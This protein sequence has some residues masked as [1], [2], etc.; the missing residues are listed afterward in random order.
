MVE[1]LLRLLK[2]CSPSRWEGVRGWAHLP[3]KVY[4][5][6]NESIKSLPDGIY[7][8]RDVVLYEAKE[9]AMVNKE[10]FKVKGSE[11]V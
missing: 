1:E 4:F 10:K 8:M 9:V 7:F 11:L 3:A 6:R 2:T 5:H